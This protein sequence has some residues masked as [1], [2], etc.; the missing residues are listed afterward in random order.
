MGPKACTYQITF[1]PAPTEVAGYLIPVS[2]KKIL[3]KTAFAA[4]LVLLSVDAANAQDNII[5]SVNQPENPLV[6]DA[7]PDLIYDGEAALTLGGAPTAAGGFGDYTYAWE[8]AEYL[9]DPTLANPTV[10]DLDGPILFTLTVSDPGAL[11][12]KQ[13]EV[14][15]D[16]SLGT[17]N[18]KRPEV[19]AFPNPFTEAVQ[20]EST[21]PILEI[22]VTDMTGQSIALL[23]N[24]QAEQY[25]LETAP[26]AV[27]MYFFIIRFADGSTTVKKLCKVH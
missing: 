21:A 24:L 14:F 15:V 23:R 1:T 3:I 6:I 22:A 10:T 2:M 20:L 11:C 18:G 27:G 13:A 4:A 16:Y 26:L 12:E 5:F 25:R 8:P 19:S 7:G 17:L 9:D